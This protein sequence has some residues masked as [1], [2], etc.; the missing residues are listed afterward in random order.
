[1][2]TVH[3]IAVLIGTYDDDFRFQSASRKSALLSAAKKAK[4]KNNPSRVRFA[5]SVDINGS[6]LFNVSDTF[7][8]FLRQDRRQK[9]SKTVAFTSYIVKYLKVLSDQTW[10]REQAC[11]I[12][13]DKLDGASSIILFHSVIRYQTYSLDKS[14]LLSSYI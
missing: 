12:R 13:Y 8:R 9:M 7:K 10:G 11:S 4:L 1:M 14:T 2:E 3:L 5:E 6:P